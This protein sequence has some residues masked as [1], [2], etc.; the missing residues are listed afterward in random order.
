VQQALKSRNY[1]TGEATGTLDQPTRDALA[2]F[3]LD[4]KQPATG[5]AD[6][7]TVTALGMN[8]ASATTNNK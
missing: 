3:Q 6:E 1:Y 8:T 4:Q 2:R 5:D 7:P